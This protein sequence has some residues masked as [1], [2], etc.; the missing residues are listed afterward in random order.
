MP[1]ENQT[2]SEKLWIEAAI[3]GDKQAFGRLYELYANR[4]F[5]Y[6]YYRIGGRAEAAD[7]TETVFLKAW[8]KLPQFGRPEKGLNFRAWLYRIAHNA[9]IDHRRTKKEEIGLDV[10]GEQP[11]PQPQA[12]QLVEESERLQ[13]LLAALERLDPAAR[14][15]I[16]LRFFSGLDHKETAAVMG[17]SKG[18]VRVIQFRALKKLKD[19]LGSE[20][21]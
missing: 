17:I 21:E 14:Q 12:A 19:Y 20:D 6:L 18:N 9:V 4:I 7:M 16:V 3:A 13:D 2:D 8:E 5:S 1:R 10:L 11:S 15:V